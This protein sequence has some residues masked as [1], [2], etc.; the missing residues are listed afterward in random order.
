MDEQEIVPADKRLRLLAILATVLA[1]GLCVF[2]LVLLR[3]E[4]LRLPE[5]GAADRRE[6]VQRMLVVLTV[7][8][9]VGG[10]SFVGTG[11]WF[12][13]LG[14]RVFRSGRFP[15]PG[16]KVIRDTPIRTGR[17]ASS[18]AW[19]TLLFGVIFPVLGCT[20]IWQLY[21]AAVEALGQ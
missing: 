13:R 1:V 19:A 3:G 12:V 11:L 14:Y 18:T 5:P 9:C 17:Q 8:A 10:S 6:A 21:R 20:G 4:L 15:P 7:I 16:M 2:G